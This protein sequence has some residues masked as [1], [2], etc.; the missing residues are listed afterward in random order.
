MTMEDFILK[1]VELEVVGVD[2]TA[3][4]LKSKEPALPP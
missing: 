1:A 3:Y 4:W 2:M